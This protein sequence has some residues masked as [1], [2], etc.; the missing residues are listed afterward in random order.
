MLP[1]ALFASLGG[2]D[3]SYAPAY[4]EET[5]LCMRIREAGYRI[6][7]EPT[8]EIS[9]FEFG[10]SNSSAD[11]LAL[12]ARNHGT[13][14]KRHAE[15]LARYHYASSASVL[16]GRS[17]SA[18]PR[19]LVVDDRVPFPWLGAGY[20]RA[21]VLLKEIE[22]NGWFI[23]FY[24][25]IIPKAEV[26]EAR[27]AFPPGIEFALD[28]GQE[29]L[30]AFLGER[31]GYYDAI[32]V[33][34]PH[35]MR[36][37]KRACEEVSEFARGVPLI[38]DAEALFTEREAIRRKLK[39]KAWSK[40]EY[41]SALREEM[42]LTQGAR[43]ILAVS[44]REKAA[45]LES[46]TGTA[47]H[48]LGHKMVACP[49]PRPFVER[50]DIL[51]VGA[52]NG[53]SE[54]APNIDSLIWFVRQI[55]PLLERSLGTD[56]LLHVIGRIES[57]EVRSLGDAHVKLHGMIPDIADFYGSCRSFVAPTRFAAGIPIKVQEASAHGLP[58]VATRL[59]AEQLGRREG[60]D[61]MVGD[62]PEEFAEACRRLYTNEA[63]WLSVRTQA[64]ESLGRECSQESFSSTMKKVLAALPVLDPVN[65]A[66]AQR[67]PGSIDSAT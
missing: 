35:N 59:L 33:S 31:I 45:F 6:V 19:M 60:F 20:P 55:L 46:A 12:Q 65:R 24:P 61:L 2:F 40:R 8:I 39:G 3:A 11:A 4:Y 63:L 16:K 27:E 43:I 26:I 53:S 1:T 23:T 32:L 49:E 30:V 9:H 62:T 25:L 28:K 54:T 5:D 57:G 7:Y 41:D 52:L 14:K 66:R 36:I 42:S 38:Y 34:R 17:T 50:R 29:G 48:V 22:S 18:K 47:V 51:F 58:V 21:A 64:L 15:T 67:R 44:Q 13:F 10:S 37:F 56:I